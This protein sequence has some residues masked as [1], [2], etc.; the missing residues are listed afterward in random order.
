MAVFIE[1]RV[2]DWVAMVLSNAITIEGL[3]SV[4][5]WVAAM[6]SLVLGKMKNR[7]KG[8]KGLGGEERLGSNELA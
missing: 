7:V 3:H 6:V 5:G 4:E 1:I 2:E 8:E